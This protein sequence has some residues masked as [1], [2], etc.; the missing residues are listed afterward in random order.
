MTS[1]TVGCN[2]QSI[3]RILA[4][5]AVS[6]VAC[7]C[8][9]CTYRR[10]QCTLALVWKFHASPWP[11]AAVWSCFRLLSVTYSNRFGPSFKGN[12][13]IQLGIDLHN[14]SPESIV[15]YFSTELQAQV[16][17]KQRTSIRHCSGPYTHP[18]VTIPS[19]VGAMY[20][21]WQ[22]SICACGQCRRLY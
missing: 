8:I 9:T 22:C 21:A 6:Q 17:R 19:F 15:R 4:I 14:P 5:F 13:S 3:F 1:P 16:L 12:Q 7:G 10:C 20:L 2:R 18:E 11:P